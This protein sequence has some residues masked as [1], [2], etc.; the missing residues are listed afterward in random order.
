MLKLADSGYPL[1]HNITKHFHGKPTSLKSSDR[2]SVLNF[3]GLPLNIFD[4]GGFFQPYLTLQQ[5]DYLSNKNTG[6]FLVGCSNDII[7]QYKQQYTD[8]VLYLDTD[9]YY[10]A[11]LEIVNKDLKDKLSLTYQDKKFIDFIV[12]QVKQNDEL[13]KARGDEDDSDTVYKTINSNSSDSKT[14]KG[15]DDFIRYNF[16]DYLIGFLSSVKYDKFMSRFH[17]KLPMG[18]MEM[19]NHIDMFNVKYVECFKATHNYKLFNDH[20][21]D[22]MFNF[23]EPKHVG[24][25]IAPVSNNLF[26][27][28]FGKWGAA[29]A[30]W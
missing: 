20:T 16:E 27:N 30:W 5:L 21:E 12:D 13:A 10:D 1:A 9:E 3:M 4:K 6:W 26:K 2:G 7:L 22:E 29:P 18:G 25:A 14:F 11:K 23:F 28:I 24:D 17:D 19:E 15:G 8:L